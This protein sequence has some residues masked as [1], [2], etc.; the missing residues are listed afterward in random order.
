MVESV[1]QTDITLVHNG[2]EI[3]IGL[4][5]RALASIISELAEQT[6]I[7]RGSMSPVSLVFHTK[8]T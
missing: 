1:A 6:D 2:K 4:S 3:V 5:V 8:V 7:L